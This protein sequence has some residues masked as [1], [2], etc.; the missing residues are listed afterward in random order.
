MLSRSDI[1]ATY[2]RPQVLQTAEL[3][4][5][6]CAFAAA[7][8]LGN[9]TNALLFREPHYDHSA[10]VVGKFAHEREHPG[11]ILRLLLI[12]LLDVGGRLNLAFARKAFRTVRYRIRGDSVE[13]R[14]ERRATPFEATQIRERVVEDR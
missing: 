13:P 10:L 4:L 3:Q 6:D 9:I 14:R 11:L 1:L 8:S 2:P 7:E 12:G 5:L